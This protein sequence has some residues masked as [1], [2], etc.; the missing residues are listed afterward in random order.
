LPPLQDWNVEIA[1]PNGDIYL[2]KNEPWKQG[3]LRIL[4]NHLWDETEIDTSLQLSQF[5]EHFTERK[6]NPD[7][8]PTISLLERYNKEWGMMRRM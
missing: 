7:T 3:S 5:K 2:V 8:H 6:K 1:L 4:Q